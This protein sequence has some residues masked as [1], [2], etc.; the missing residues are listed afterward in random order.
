MSLFRNP[1]TA[2]RDSIRSAGSTVQATATRQSLAAYRRLIEAI[3]AAAVDILDNQLTTRK[4]I[5]EDKRAAA[6]F[7]GSARVG[8]E[9]YAID[10]SAMFYRLTRKGTKWSDSLGGF[11]RMPMTAAGMD[12]EQIWRQHGTHVTDRRPAG[13]VSAATLAA[14]NYGGLDGDDLYAWGWRNDRDVD[15]DIAQAMEIRRSHPNYL[16]GA[17]IAVTIVQRAIAVAA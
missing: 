8:D 13:W 3:P 9:L 4:A 14:A 5:R 2:A 10:G 15:L 6:R 16:T 7:V 17:N 1:K 11:H 12:V